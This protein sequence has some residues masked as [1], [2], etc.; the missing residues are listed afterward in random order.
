MNF[1]KSV[2]SEPDGSGSTSRVMIGLLT[3]FI[4]G[5]GISFSVLVCNKH[6]TVEQFEGFLS[7]S[8]T[9]LLTTCGPL[10]GINKA[11][12]VMKGRGN[13]VSS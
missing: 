12:D 5:V 8:S 7:N 6:I 1:F 9:F 10:Y 4:L 3:A 13:N 11:A 2:F